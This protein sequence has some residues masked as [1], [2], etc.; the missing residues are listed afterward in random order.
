MIFLLVNFEFIL[1]YESERGGEEGRVFD[2]GK[3]WRNFSA[4]WLE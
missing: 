3:K 1:A 2:K 4:V